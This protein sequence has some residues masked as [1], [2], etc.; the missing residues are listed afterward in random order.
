MSYLREREKVILTAEVWEEYSYEYKQLTFSTPL[1][2]YSYH[3]TLFKGEKKNDC[4][5]SWDIGARHIMTRENVKI[6]VDPH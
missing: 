5:V 6:P 2:I 1:G 3:K 4:Q